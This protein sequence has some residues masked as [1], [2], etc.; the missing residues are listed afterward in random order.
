MAATGTLGSRLYM[1]TAAIAEGIDTEREF[2]AQ[3]WQEIGLI[4]NFGEFGRVFELASFQAVKDGRTYK[5]KA[6]FNDGAL[7]MGFGQDLSDAG[8]AL[9]KTAAES[10]SQ[11]NYGFRVELND[12]PSTVGGPTTFF[13]RGLAMSFRTVMGAANAVIKANSNIE[14]NS[15]ILA[16]D[17]AELYDR[18]VT[19][20][21]LS[22]YELFNGS[23]AQAVDPAI[24]SD[25][26]VI[27][28]GDAGTGDAA[29]LSEAVGDTGYV[30]SSGAIVFETKVKFSAITNVYGFFGFTDN[31]A[32]LE[33]PI[34]SA[35]SA[36]TLTSNAS[37]AVGFMFDT[38]MSTDNWWLT[39][40]AGDSDATAQNVGSAPV[41]DTYAVLRIEITTGGVATFYIN[42]TIVGSAMTGA[43]TA[44]ATIYPVL[45]ASARSTTSRTVTADYLYVRQ[46]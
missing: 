34:I 28:T 31:K 7:N 24:S 26:L 15:P 29:D 18:F 3:E 11:D 13:F 1:T 45:C 33:A 6:G 40:V 22:H 30:P 25:T 44:G 39:G 10:S 27:V 21:S 36:N 41:A 9:L 16:V 35:A 20:G 5:L 2:S 4:E 23:D 12:P 42:G 37:D 19:G 43:V 46:S 8:Q 38:A 14:V 32:S 17:P